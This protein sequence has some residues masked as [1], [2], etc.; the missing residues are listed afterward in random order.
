MTLRDVRKQRG[1]SQVELAA[2]ARVSQ[3]AISQLEI[4]PTSAA[5]ARWETVYRVSKV[6]GVKPEK[7]FPVAA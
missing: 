6:L 5:G 1:L 2:L 7:L 4:K 3:N